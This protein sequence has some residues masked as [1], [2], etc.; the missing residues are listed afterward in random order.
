MKR[1]ELLKTE[2]YWL[3]QM[4]NHV[5]NLINNYRNEHKLN[6]SQIA[7]KLKVSKGYVSQILNGDF[8]HKVSKLVNLALTFN[9]API[10]NFVDIDKYINDDKEGKVSLNYQPIYFI[11]LS[12]NC[13]LKLDDDHYKTISERL[14]REF[15]DGN[16]IEVIGHVNTVDNF[17]S[18]HY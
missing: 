1:E 6:Q 5:F 12:S 3:I 17:Y 14:G 16:T 7:E 8:D 13:I 18:T 11:S 15:K 4:Q 2:E 10:L 9:K